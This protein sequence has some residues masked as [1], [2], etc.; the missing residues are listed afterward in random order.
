MSQDRPLIAGLEQEWRRENSH[1][2]SA[3]KV[4]F[5]RQKE[6]W[7][8]KDRTETKWLEQ[9]EREGDSWEGFRQGEGE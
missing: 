9:T 4:M 8:W 5:S 6:A 7:C 3:R 2:K 1:G